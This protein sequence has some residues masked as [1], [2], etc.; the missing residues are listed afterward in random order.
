MNKKKL[1][2]LPDPEVDIQIAIHQQRQVENMNQTRKC[3][4]W[5][6]A[7]YI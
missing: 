7:I 4:Y 1:K 3:L 5:K 6:S 2:I